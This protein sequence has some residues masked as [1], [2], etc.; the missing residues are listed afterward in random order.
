VRFVWMMGADN[1]KYFH[2]WKNWANIFTMLPVAV[3]DR[4][5]MSLSAASGAAAMRFARARI[6]E[7]QAATL[8]G[9][10]PP[11][12]VYLHGV[13]SSL[14]STALRNGKKPPAGG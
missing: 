12:W 4:G 1:L 3:V 14:S 7:L 6:P 10:E 9:R 5:G 11:A 2:R 13:K 8:A